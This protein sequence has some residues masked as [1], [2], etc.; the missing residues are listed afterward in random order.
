MKRAFW[1]AIIAFAVTAI[2]GGFLSG[3][4]AVPR[5]P[6]AVPSASIAPAPPISITGSIPQTDELANDDFTNDAAVTVDGS[7]GDVRSDARL[8]LAI[9]DA[10]HSAALESP[11]L[12]LGVP[13]TLVVDPSGPAADQMVRAAHQSGQQVYMQARLPL[14]KAEIESL[15]AAFAGA[16]GIAARLQD[17]HAAGKGVCA[18]LR[19]LNWSLFD[20][21]GAR[22]ELAHRFSVC[23]V[24]YVARSITVD[25]H[26][27]RTY[28][29]YMLDQ[30]VHLARGRTTVVM[31]RPFPGTLRALQDVLARAPR[32][33]IRFTR[34]P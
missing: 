18:A 6:I 34:M 8:A 17:V 4:A 9:V 29:A 20:E 11:F 2:S 32:D 10:G 26:V 31:A 13:V 25:D 3:R 16:D 5:F 28:V 15:H 19:A 27:Q 21:Y 33:G 7:A 12:G 24:R 22:S 23:G 30:A 14:R 1:L